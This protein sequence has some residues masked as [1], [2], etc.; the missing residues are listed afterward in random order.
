[1]EEPT[2]AAVDAF[3]GATLLEFGASWC[4]YC[5]AA[6]PDIAA[7]LAKHPAVRHVKVED[8]RGRPLGRSFRVK[9][10][11]TL[12]YLLDGIEQAR[13]VRPDSAADIEA[14]FAS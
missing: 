7:V 5:L 8:G 1:M 12:F 3:S 6:Q 14:I 9:L 4:G 2:R 10:W 13:V 11:P